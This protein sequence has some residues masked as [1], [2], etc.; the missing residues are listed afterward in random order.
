MIIAVSNGQPV[1]N[2]GNDRYA[3]LNETIVL[4]G[5]ASNDPDG[6]TLTYS[7]GFITKPDDS[8]ATLSDS[9]TDH[10]TFTVDE[11]G[12][13]TLRLTVTDEQGYTDTDE[14]NILESPTASAGADL[15]AMQGDTV[16]LDGS[17][18]YDPED[19]PLSYNWSFAS[20]PTGSSAM[21]SGATSSSPSFTADAPGDFV[22]SLIVSDGNADSTAD[23]VTI[24]VTDGLLSAS[25]TSGVAPLSVFFKAGFSGSPVTGSGKSFHDLRY[26]WDFGDTSTDTWAVSEKSKNIA[27][28]PV[29]AHVFENPG[30]YTVTLTTMDTA[31]ISTETIDITVT[32]PD[33][34]YAG[35]NTICISD[36][37][38]NDFTGCPSGAQQIA[39]DS[40]ATEIKSNMA[41]GKRILL[42]RGSSWAVSD[43][44]TDQRSIGSSITG[45][46]TIGAYGDC[47]SPDDRGI[48]ANAPVINLSASIP[49]GQ[50][51]YLWPTFF[52]VSNSSDMRIHDITF[53][54]DQDYGCLLGGAT[55]I[56]PIL[57]LRIK[58]TGFYKDIV[59][60]S[61]NTDSHDQ[62]TI[63]DSDFSGT[64]ST[65]A[66]VGSKQLAYM[67]TR[68]CDS[69]T[70]HVLR[71]WQAHLAV[72]SHN[73]VS[74][75][76]LNTTSGLHALKL[77]GLN[78]SLI[79]NPTKPSHRTQFVVISDNVF[80]GSGPWPVATG[81][82]NGEYDERL[83]D[84]IFQRNRFIAGYGN[85]SSRLVS[86]G[87]VV[88]A[89]Y[90]T[91][92]NNIFDGTGSDES[93][94]SMVITRRGIEPAPVG[95]RIYNNTIFKDDSDNATSMFIGVDVGEVNESVILK[96]NLF[97]LP[98]T[99][100]YTEIYRESI[101]GDVI[102]SHNSLN[103]ADLTFNDS[104]N[105]DLLLRDFDIYSDSSSTSDKAI[106]NG[107]TV[108]VYRD[109]GGIERPQ[110]SVWDRGAF[111]H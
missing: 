109:I 96:N 63:V 41:T 107:D 46:V 1:A 83:S 35:T 4:D 13:F 97:Q 69:N 14:I 106:D 18:S 34:I 3:W 33:T 92:R 101:P 7:W 103:A 56:G 84:I 52:S 11:K 94:Y 43:S 29:A 76:S 91:I 58:T 32:D 80:G 8:N 38:S 71:L 105:A 72:I 61:Y 57:L 95:T 64:E 79:D 54:A 70:S 98:T 51:G 108:P 23:T 75:S 82:Q 53:S 36:A 111:E 100:T 65:M 26:K 81:P 88:E 27:D 37:A 102:A 50:P 17:E 59:I 15:E 31:V 66:Y 39:T 10:P 104:T 6:G 90:V 99:G 45:P 87:L 22:A 62:F 55:N 68:F 74:G 73:I 21:F 12:L 40:V 78:E 2:A 47:S 60:S 30:T 19:D 16:T 44:D 24:S 42:R 20:R 89:R 85:L 25:R 9:D 86:K 93:Y 5:S 49:Y 67:G 48:C 77:H 28:G 110:N